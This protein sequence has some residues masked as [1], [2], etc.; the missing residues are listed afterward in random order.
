MEYLIRKTRLPATLPAPW[1]SPFWSAADTLDVA[2]FHPRSASTH[3]KTRARLLYDDAGLY[4]HF[5]VRDRWVR[6]AHTD[7]QS[8]VCQDSC[9]EFFVRPKDGQGYFNFEINP[10]GT[11]LLYFVEDPTRLEGGRL[12]KAQPVPPNLGATVR[13]HTSE[14]RPI[15]DEIPDD[16][17]WWLQYF[18]PFDLFDRYLVGPVRPSPGDRWHANFY[19]CGDLTSHPHWAAWSPVGD[20]LNFHQPDKFG[21]IRFE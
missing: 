11:M 18:V 10:V 5:H 15:P 8:P 19:K 9:A 1:D 2:H 16:R 20:A 7:Y 21:L 14:P 12:R 3:P 13:I 6:A 4:V 17:D